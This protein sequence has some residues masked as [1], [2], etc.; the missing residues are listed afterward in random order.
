MGRIKKGILGGFSG[1]VG[2]VVGAS[3]LGIDYMRS[4]PKISNKP[5]SPAQEGQRNKMIRLR[6]FLIGLGNIINRS[7]QN[8]AEKTPMN[9]ALSYNMKN[10]LTGISPDFEIHFPNLLFSQGNLHGTWSPKVNS[11]EPAALDFI[12]KNSSF[13]P[14]CGADD[15][16][17]A[18]VYSPAD[19]KFVLL[20]DLV[21][22]AEAAVRLILPKDFSG[23]L[24]HCYLGFHSRTKGISSTNQYL[25]E[26]RVL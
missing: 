25:G 17:I 8:F 1:K 11:T 19:K 12:W 15:E 22:R 20:N 14:M 9:A 21:T 23:H 26:I 24:V 10:A 4:L 13:S 18:V 2:S 3:W 7:F 16:L 6:A 5:A